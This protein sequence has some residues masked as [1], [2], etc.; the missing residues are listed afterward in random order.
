MVDSYSERGPLRGKEV[1]AGHH[2]G[3]E[4]DPSTCVERPCWS[5]LRERLD[6][7]DQFTKGGAAEV[8]SELL[9]VLPRHRV[10]TESVF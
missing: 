9:E 3:M 1:G 6:G 10:V 7:L 8:D 4:Q 5:S 2:P